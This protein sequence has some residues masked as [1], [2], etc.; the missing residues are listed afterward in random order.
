MLAAVLAALP[1][2]SPRWQAGPPRP[3]AMHDQPLVDHG[4]VV[5]A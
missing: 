2:G 5:V 3:I 4:L 1:S